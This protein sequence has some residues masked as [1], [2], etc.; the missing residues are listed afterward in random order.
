MVRLGAHMSIAGGVDEALKRGA[1]VGCDTIAIFTKGPSRWAPRPLSEDEIAR[2]RQVQQDTGIHP[3][4]GHDSY[5]CNVGSPDPEL[6]NK[7]LDD[8]LEEV[9]HCE[10]LGLPYL[11]M[12][13][14]AHM[15]SGPEEGLKRIA[16][17][18]DEVHSRTPGYRTRILLE[19]TAGAGSVL[20]QSFDQLRALLDLVKEHGRLGVCFDTCHVYA[21]GYDIATCEGYE[22]T[23]RDLD[24]QV[25]LKRVLAFHLNDSAGELGKHRDRHAHIG[26]GHLGLEPFRWLLNDPRFADRPMV[27]ETDKS[28]DMHED[29]EN[30]R[31][32]RELVGTHE[33]S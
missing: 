6:W 1:Q 10:A 33:N 15:G 30:L 32:L 2:F 23:M 12:H 3:V 9:G 28:P 13:P 24:K 21:A 7:S 17:A 20:G 5:L 4:F 27:L 22:A 14:G 31:R 19:T 25:G 8:L 26:E 11:V 16:Q 29:V 18:L